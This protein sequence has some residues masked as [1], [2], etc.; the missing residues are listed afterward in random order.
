MAYRD[1][2]LQDPLRDAFTSG[3][4][5]AR[6]P[7]N[8]ALPIL[9]ARVTTIYSPWYTRTCPECCQKFR[10]ADRVRLCPRCGQAYHDD[11]QYH[12]YCWQHHFAEGRVCKRGGYDPIAERDVSGC[13][14][15]W[16]GTLPDTG[17]TPRRD[18]GQA[19][20]VEL[21]TVQFLHGLE[22]IWK[23]FGDANLHEVKVGEAIIGHRCPWCRYQVRAG[24]TELSNVPV[25]SAT[26]IS[27]TMCFGT[28]HVGTT[29]MADV[30]T[31]IARPQGPAFLHS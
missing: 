21:I 5:A 15:Q 31:A 1:V 24:G 13:L 16:S 28:S 23:P 11:E 27:T 22:T 18:V 25:G 20:R 6:D 9:A 17:T 3:L 26:P 10:E 2:P 19:R 12:L 30:G 29:G 7:V 14:Y 4:A 8:A